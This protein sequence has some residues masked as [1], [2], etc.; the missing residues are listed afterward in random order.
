MECNFMF[1][2]FNK[3]FDSIYDE[4]AW[5]ALQNHNVPNKIINT[6]KYFYAN[7]TAYI[8]MDKKKE[9]F[10]IN[11]RV[12]QGD[13]LSPN[14]FISV[15]EKVFRNLEWEGQGIKINGQWLNN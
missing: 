15:L 11:R 6:L 10:P 3:A 2:D 1:I 4:S 5:T 12:K 8:Q 14:I 9:E 13:P 7:S